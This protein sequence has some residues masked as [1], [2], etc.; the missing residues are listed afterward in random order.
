MLRLLEHEIAYAAG[1]FDGEGAFVARY[2][3]SNKTKYF[4]ADLANT[5]L[6]VLD[7]HKERFSGTIVKRLE[8]Y[9]ANKQ[10]YGWRVTSSNAYNYIAAIL[11]FLQ[12]KEE[13]AKFMLTI[14]EQRGDLETFQRLCSERKERWG[15]GATA[16]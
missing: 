14:W 3:E 4:A 5:Y 2:Q 7:W 10:C 6:P 11:P 1:F 15:R 12:Y 13:H 16:S 9:N 8:K